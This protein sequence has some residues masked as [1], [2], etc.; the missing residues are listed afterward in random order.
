M[1]G[2]SRL[3]RL[4]LGLGSLLLAWGCADQKEGDR[5]DT[6]NGNLDCEAPLVCRLP[7]GRTTA[8]CCPSTLTT[9]T[10]PECNPALTIED[11][12]V[13]PTEDATA[14]TSTSPDAETTGDGAAEASPDASAETPEAA[15]ESGADGASSEDAAD[16]AAE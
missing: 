15:V 6:R 5:C 3:A 14:D 11:A 4:A 12:A 10:V 2:S 7:T 16:G 13:A 9:T 8:L 1:N